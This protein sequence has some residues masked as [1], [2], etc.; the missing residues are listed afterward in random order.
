[1][2]RL[3]HRPAPRLAPLLA[4]LLLG[5]CFKPYDDLPELDFTEIRYENPL[6]VSDDAVVT[7]FDTDLVCPDGQ[8][9]RLIAVYRTDLTGPQPVAIVLHSGAFDTLIPQEGP[10]GQ[11]APDPLTFRAQSRLTRPW[12]IAKVWETLGISSREIDG[13]EVNLGALPAALTDA[14]VIQLYPANCWGDLWHGR[15][16]PDN[17]EEP[18]EADD[19][20]LQRD[21]LTLAWWSVRFLTEGNFA[22]Q[23]G[24]SIPEAD[25]S[26]LF[27]VG[28]GEGGRGVGEL[29]NIGNMPP[30]EGVLVDSSPDRLEPWLAD[31]LAWPDEVAALAD[32]YGSTDPAVVDAGSLYNL[33]KDGRL[34][35]RAGFVWSRIDPQV[36]AAAAQ[37]TADT[38]EAETA[39]AWVWDLATPT[40]IQL[41]GDSALAGPAAEW[42]LTGDLPPSE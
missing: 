35:A 39:G 16:T 6:L 26:Q 12:S 30:V 28:L 20:T 8:P 33:A 18:P 14:G 32:I 38:L 29:L 42:L 25:P 4:G 24:F 31:P 1:M 23:Q 22:A 3:P 5:G 27:L 40:H 34:D 9:A 37:P 11:P 7:A 15:A 36:P 19:D 17:G 2:N 13:S 10:E 21:G 41:N